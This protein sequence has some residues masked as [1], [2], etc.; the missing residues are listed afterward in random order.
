MTKTMKKQCPELIQLCPPNL[1]E[2]LTFCKRQNRFVRKK[3]HI[4]AYANMF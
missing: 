3:K 2:A 4:Y 1:S